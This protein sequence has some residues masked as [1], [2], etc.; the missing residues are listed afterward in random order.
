MGEEGDFFAKKLPFLPHTP[1]Y[2][3]KNKKI[4]FENPFM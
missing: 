3:Q 2:L 4:F 1:S